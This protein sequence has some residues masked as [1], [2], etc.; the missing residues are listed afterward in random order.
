MLYYI[1]SIIK[2]A[3][4]KKTLGDCFLMVKLLSKFRVCEFEIF[5]SIYQFLSI[6]LLVIHTVAV[7]QGFG[8]KMAFFCAGSSNEVKKYMKHS[9]LNCCCCCHFGFCCCYCL[10]QSNMK[11]V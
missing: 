2:S 4:K 11:L 10:C 3:E 8:D 6:V 7:K 9:E 5:L 1:L